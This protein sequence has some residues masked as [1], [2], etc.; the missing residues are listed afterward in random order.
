MPVN[1]SAA[2]REALVTNLTAAV[3]AALREVFSLND[4]G[5]ARA[6]ATAVTKR[7]PGRM[8]GTKA[9]RPQRSAITRWVPDRRARRVP[10][11]VIEATGLD[12]KKKIVTRYGEN[13]VFQKGKPVPQLLA[14]RG[15]AVR[16]AAPKKSPRRSPKK[17]QAKAA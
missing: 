16:S 2:L 5:P 11:F 17:K 10:T 6:S 15:A 4:A 8:P 1:V 12:T 13:A 7:G 3:D 9:R 14:G